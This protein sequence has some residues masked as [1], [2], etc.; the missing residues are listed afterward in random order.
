MNPWALLGRNE[1][2]GAVYKKGVENCG[3]QIN[4]A[5]SP[6]DDGIESGA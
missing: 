5:A 1:H 3:N 4:K 2:D 6:R